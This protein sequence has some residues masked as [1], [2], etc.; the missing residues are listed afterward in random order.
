[1]NRKPTL[2]RVFDGREHEIALSEH[3]RLQISGLRAVHGIS[4][5]L[6]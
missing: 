6:A 5:E 1:L 2:I 4:R 3:G